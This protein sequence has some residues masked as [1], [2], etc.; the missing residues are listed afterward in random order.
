MMDLFDRSGASKLCERRWYT[1]TARG[2]VQRVY[3][4]LAIFEV[5]PAGFIVREI[6]DG[7]SFEELQRKVAVGLKLATSI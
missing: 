3:T 2:G 5:A 6:V 7:L 1:L 4:D